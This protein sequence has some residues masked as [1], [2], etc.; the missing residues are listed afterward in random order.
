MKISEKLFTGCTSFI[1]ILL[2]HYSSLAQEIT[3]LSK[4][5]IHIIPYPQEVKLRGDD[6]TLGKKLTI[7]LDK[8]ATE[9]DKFAAD[10]LAKYLNE[11][12]NIQTII[13]NAP[14][15]KSII[16][17]RKMAAKKSGDEGYTLTTEKDHVIVRAKTESGLFY[18]VQTFL[19]LIQ[20]NK[21]GAYVK[22][23]EIVDW[24]ATPVRAIHYDNLY[25]QD[26]RAYVEN[27]I[28][29]L[30]KYKINMLVWE[31][32]DKFDYP[33]H[34]EIGVPGAFTM[35][36]VQEIT[37]YARKYHIQIVPLVQGLGHVQ[38]ILKWP[39]L[40]HLREIPASNWEFCPLK[41]GTYDL[42]F[43]LWDDAVKATPG[44]E[45]IHIGSDETYELGLCP[46]CKKK[47]EEIGKTGL[48]HLFTAKSAKHLQAEGRQVMVWETPMGW[49]K[50]EKA[51][52]NNTVPQK[53]IIL[54]ESYNYETPD[55]KYAKEAKLMV[56]R[57]ML[58]I[59]TRG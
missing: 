24:P 1:L 13:Q 22:G 2:F 32:G 8:T 55:L 47:A 18:G 51:I 57:C 10:E 7:V 31:W 38:F 58:T 45:Y 25:H 27:F 17:T 59:Q 49:T 40:A 44:S 56:I 26:T 46:D 35:K 4:A 5:G 42:L 6:F 28:R 15:G 11:K 12:L 41:E 29:D 48:Y 39:Q 36:E 9:N 50:D 37:H 14:F 16:L 43:D 3:E 34:P 20:K 30:A 33:S 52:K 54:T 19:Q 21:T 53:G 23:M